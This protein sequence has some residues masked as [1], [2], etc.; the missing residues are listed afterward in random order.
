MEKTFILSCESTVD[1]PY[2]YISERNISI[3]FYTYSINGELFTDNM[4]QDKNN[5]RDFY[6]KLDGGVIVKTSQINEFKYYDYFDKLLV[7]NDVVHI[8]IIV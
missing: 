3:L 5:L 2:N 4:Q 7:N 1:L 8:C 6:E